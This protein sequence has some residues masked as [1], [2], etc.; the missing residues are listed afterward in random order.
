ML[1]NCRLNVR[2]GSDRVGMAQLEINSQAIETCWRTSRPGGPSGPRGAI[3]ARPI[4]EWPVSLVRRCPKRVLEPA[5]PA[6]QAK[7][8]YTAGAGR[9]TLRV[10]YHHCAPI[11][12]INGGDRR[13]QGPDI[14]RLGQKP[15]SD[16][17]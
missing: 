9:V 11:S 4:A 8:M 12:D 13:L 10:S 1:I 16:S 5:V 6:G 15:F 2:L 7:T 17:V 14:G 3:R